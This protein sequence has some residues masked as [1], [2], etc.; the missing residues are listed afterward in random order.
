MATAAEIN[1]RFRRSDRA[2]GIGAIC[3]GIVAAIA[4][5]VSGSEYSRILPEYSCILFAG[6]ALLL[7]AGGLVI[8]G[9]IEGI[10][11][12]GMLTFITL[13]QK[14][15]SSKP[16]MVLALIG[17]GYSQIT[18]TVD[19]LLLLGVLI[20]CINRHW[21]DRDADVPDTPIVVSKPPPPLTPSEAAEHLD[22]L[23]NPDTDEPMES[24]N[25]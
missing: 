4:L 20:Y 15:S 3:V 22:R 17:G 9:R 19:A 10:A 12:I 13:I 1:A 5:A 24:S 14:V 7:F 16:I 6:C 23:S 8:N 25:R 21:D 18:F 11:L 2:L